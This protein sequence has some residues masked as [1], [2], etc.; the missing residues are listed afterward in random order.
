GQ[1]VIISSG[2]T[3]TVAV[4]SATPSAKQMVMSTIDN[5]VFAVRLSANNVEN[6]KVTDLSFL[7]TITGNTAGRTSFK[8][9]KVYDGASFVGP[10][11]PTIAGTT[12]STVPFSFTTPIIVPKNGSKTLV[13]KGDLGTYDEGAISGSGHTW[14]INATSTDVTAYGESSNNSAVV[15]FSGTVGGSAMTVYRTKLSLTASLLGAATGRSRASVDDLATVNWT[16]NSAYQVLLGTVSIKFNGFAV[17][18]GSPNFTVDLLKSDGT[19]FGGSTETCSPGAGNS[20]SVTFSPQFTIS[21]GA[22]QGTKV[23]VNSSSFYDVAY[24]QGLSVLINAASDIAWND[25]VI[26]GIGLEASAVPFTLAN[27]SY[28]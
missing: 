8:D 4:D 3:L 21:S 5:S 23:R 28:E 10:R 11:T 12:T 22:T 1:D 27:T 14:S 9:M 24:G 6:I 13:L 17:S 2:P 20:C 19:A 18:N 15:S 25:G 26:G 7:D 16:A